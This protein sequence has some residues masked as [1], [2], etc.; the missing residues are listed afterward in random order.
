MRSLDEKIQWAGR[1]V[2]VQPRI[3]LTRSFDERSHTYQGYVLRVQGTLGKVSGEFLVAV[4][5]TA[6]AKHRFSVGDEVQGIGH[7]VV[8]PRMETA[9]I[10]KVSGLKVLMRT[11]GEKQEGPPWSGVPPSLQVY[12]A[13]GHRRLAAR[14]YE[15]KCQGCIWGCNMA[16][17]MIIDHWNPHVRRYRTETFCYGPLSCPF[18]KPGPTRKVPGRGGITYEEENW[19]DEETTSHRH[20]DE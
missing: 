2:A 9:E 15:T 13:R 12:R 8:D 7:P 1:V 3:R 17:E 6:H 11:G 5:P 16:V 4:G 10:Y 18:Y 20:P 19:V 14:T